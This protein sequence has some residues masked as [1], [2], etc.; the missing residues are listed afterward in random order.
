MIVCR[1]TSTSV[2]ENGEELRLEEF[3]RLRLVELDGLVPLAPLDDDG[4]CG[5]RLG[6]GFRHL[7]LLCVFFWD[8]LEVLVLACAAVAARP[9]GSGMVLGL[10]RRVRLR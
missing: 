5:L 2:S 1:S 4:D 10:R 8:G 6:E 9:V 7:L 3:H